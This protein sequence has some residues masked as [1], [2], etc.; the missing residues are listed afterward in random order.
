MAIYLPIWQI[1]I[2]CIAV[3]VVSFFF[4]IL[5]TS[6]FRKFTARLQGRTGPWFIVPKSLRPIVGATRILQPFWDIVKLMYKQT[7]V[8]STAARKVFILAPFVT[9]FFLILTLWFLPIIGISPF[10]PFEFSLI[11]FLYMLVGAPLSIVLSGATSSSPWGS[12]GSHRE[13]TMSLA[14]EIPFVFG[15]F[16]IAM[17]TGLITPVFDIIPD[18]PGSLSLLDIIQFQNQHFISFFGFNIPA[19]FLILNPFAAVA[20]MASLIGK[21]Q[22][23]PMDIVE[24]EVE[25][26]SGAYTE[27]SGKL[28]GIYEITKVL[29]L[30]I[31]LTFFIDLFLGGAVISTDYFGIPW[32]IWSGIVFGIESIV[33]ILILS[34]IH[35]ANPRFRPDQAFYWYMK[36][37]LLLSLIGFIWPYIIVWLSSV[38]VNVGIVL[39]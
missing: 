16:S 30:F 4:G 39:I 28:L 6:L 14:A 25:I 7:L 33:I 10:G 8:P 3:P 15:V 11:I 5:Y 38:G 17:M 37:P 34:I 13:V 20:V 27:Y 1:I 9:S 24:A 29:M 22:I 2:L 26:V 19:Y 32:F 21:L 36:V 35:A 23:K 12:I 31:L 18:I